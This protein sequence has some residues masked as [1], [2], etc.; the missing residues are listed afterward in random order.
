MTKH[1]KTRAP[2]IAQEFVGLWQA[3]TDALEH[4]ALPY[5]DHLIAAA[6]AAQPLTRWQLRSLITDMIPGMQFGTARRL[7]DLKYR[8]LQDSDLVNPEILN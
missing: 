3:H 4:T 7:V 8:N 1:I 5:I 2:Q 6:V